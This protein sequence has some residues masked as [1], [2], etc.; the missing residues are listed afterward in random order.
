[1]L[2]T[3]LRLPDHTCESY[4]WILLGFPSGFTFLYYL[5]LLMLVSSK[6]MRNT[7][8]LL[9]TFISS[10]PHRSCS[11][12]FVDISMF[13]LISCIQFFCSCFIVHLLNRIF[14]HSLYS[15]LAPFYQQL[16]VPVLMVPVHSPASTFQCS[17]S[18]HTHILSVPVF[19]VLFNRLQ[20]FHWHQ[21]F[22]PLFS[23]WFT[24]SGLHRSCLFVV[25][26][27]S[28]APVFMSIPPYYTWFSRFL[29]KN[30]VIMY[31]VILCPYFVC[32]VHII[33]SL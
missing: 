30:P 14:L 12:I 8:T 1:M 25:V 9:S 3:E 18:S 15:S 20:L 7:C 32:S 22:L 27:S 11:F 10:C 17:W 5:F 23:T 26:N 28:L 6:F 2:F 13:L 29:C 16:S 21:R 31:P 33:F 24:C 19:V 4:L